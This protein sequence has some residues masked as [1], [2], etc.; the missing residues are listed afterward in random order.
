MERK[1][2]QAV[3][4]PLSCH[5]PPFIENS[6]LGHLP[7]FAPAYGRPLDPTFTFIDKNV[8]TGYYCNNMYG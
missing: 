7:P 1:L 6:I 3:S 2:F 4:T 5:L 8:I